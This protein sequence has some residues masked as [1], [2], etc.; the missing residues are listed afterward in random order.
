MFSAIVV[1]LLWKSRFRCIRRFIRRRC[2]RNANLSEA[3]SDTNYDLEF[4]LDHIDQQKQ[5][6]ERYYYEKFNPT[7]PEAFT[8]SKENTA[9]WIIEHRKVWQYH[10]NNAN[11]NKY[12]SAPTN[13]QQYRI[14]RATKVTRLQHGDTTPPT[15]TANF[16]M[17]SINT[18]NTLLGR[19]AKSKR[20]VKRFNCASSKMVRD[21]MDAKTQLL[22]S[23]AR[24][25]AISNTK[26]SKLASKSSPSIRKETPSPGHMLLTAAAANSSPSNSLTHVNSLKPVSSKCNN[27]LDL[28]GSVKKVAQESP[29]NEQSKILSLSFP[30][31]AVR[32]IPPTSISI[33]VNERQRNPFII[34]RNVFSKRLRDLKRSSEAAVRCKI[35]VSNHSTENNSDS[36]AV[37]QQSLSQ[38]VNLASNNSKRAY[39]NAS[40]CKK[41][42]S[43]SWPRCRHDFPNIGRE[44]RFNYH[45][46]L[47][48]IINRNKHSLHNRSKGTLNSE[49]AQKAPTPA[50]IVMEHTPSQSSQS[51][52]KASPGY[53]QTNL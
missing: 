26:F 10:Y 38:H 53:A 36:A 23:Y 41:R 52:G 16:V 33:N 22:I 12:L 49:T 43:N 5:K 48:G 34:I 14:N 7:L 21:D 8:T 3:S 29:E 46:M 51:F 27:L 2:T 44:T 20:P 11:K 39:M 4:W 30:A 9:A 50:K 37:E 17:R 31:P 32:V 42:R 35:L 6:R 15:G 25:D 45:R 40:S 18:I 13:Q 47:Q 24:I 28:P 19:R 1:Y